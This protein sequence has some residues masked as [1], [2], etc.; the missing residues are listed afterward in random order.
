M[1][2]EQ[3]AQREAREKES[4]EKAAAK[5]LSLPAA[6]LPTAA[7]M[8]FSRLGMA[9]DYLTKTGWQQVGINEKGQE[10][11]S[12]P[13]GG[14][15]AEI[16]LAIT[17]PGREDQPGT[18]VKQLYLPPAS[19]DYPTDLAVQLQRERE[20]GGDTLESTI[21]AKERELKELREQLAKNKEAEVKKAS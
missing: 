9:Y 4:R 13:K 12:D 14:G 19:W 11:W 1:A 21:A 20:R 5:Q 15:K 16:K 17:L 10:L 3:L 7:E 8:A 18:P 2:N 6:P